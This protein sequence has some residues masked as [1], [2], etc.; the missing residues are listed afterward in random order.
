M[1]DVDGLIKQGDWLFGKKSQLISLWQDIAENFYPERAD[2]TFQRQV[3]TDFAGHLMSSRPLLVRRELGNT[4]SSMLRPRD[5]AW[6]SITVDREEK[7]DLSGREWLEWASDVQR[8][9]MYDRNTQFVRATKEGDNDFATF[10]QCA[11]SR[12]IDW[13]QTSLLYHC[14]HLRDVA[15]AEDKN[16][17][18][19]EVHRRWKP[20]L[21]QLAACFPGKMHQNANTWLE[22]EPFR[23]IEC[24]HVVMRTE[25]YSGEKKFRTPYV[26][27]HFDVENKHC[28]EEVGVY[29]QVYTIPRWQTVSG[30]QYAYSPA[31]IIALPDARLLQAMT[32]TLLEAGETAVRPPVIAVK[33]AI[34]GDVAVYAGGITWVDAEYDER[35]G[36]VLRPLTQDKRGV[37]FGV[38][39][40]QGIEAQLMEAFFLNKLGLPP[41]DHEMTAFETAQRIEE[42][43]RNAL[44]LF[45]PMETEYNAALCEDTFEAL[46]RVGAFGAIDDIP[47]SIRGSEVQFKFESP[48]HRALEKDK[49]QR[50]QEG[51]ALVI[52]A[53]E[54]DPTAANVL[55]ARIALRDALQGAGVPAKW[56]R[57]EDEVEA[58]A[59]E[60]AQQQ[61]MAQLAQ[62]A[63]V[64]GRGAKDLAQADQT[65]QQT[66][67]AALA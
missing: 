7:L 52:A 12:E 19:C 24:R 16:G 4:F 23:E 33:E 35:L 41:A 66:Q 57:D 58:M 65:V 55:D 32:L 29:S 60:A 28:L 44:P 47:Q 21:R 48:L 64:G 2:F 40:A 31:T 3:G 27:I 53:T 17:K 62:L 49:S 15:W 51:R 26:S 46:M 22:K 50:F 38:E 6:F 30:S 34:R 36:E 42:Y 8:R 20:T 43:I 59:Q 9:A 5:R 61:Q 11:I 25:D 10:G 18:I 45:E 14:W 13:R 39:M 1:A 37:P 54:L 63:Q 67:Q 56:M